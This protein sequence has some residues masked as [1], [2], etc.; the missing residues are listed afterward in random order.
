MST[1]ADVY[2]RLN[3]DAA[4][5]RVDRARL[6]ARQRWSATPQSVQKWQIFM[7]Q[8]TIRNPQTNPLHCVTSQGNE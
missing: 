7:I 2:A 5:L 6:S 1:W 8:S 4:A 3:I